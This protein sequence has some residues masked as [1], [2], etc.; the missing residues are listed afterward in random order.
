MKINDEFFERVLVG[1]TLGQAV[2]YDAQFVK[3]G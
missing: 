2:G 3:H 1:H